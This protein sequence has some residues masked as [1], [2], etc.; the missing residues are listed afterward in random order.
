MDLFVVLPWIVAIAVVVA[1]KTVGPVVAAAAV[2]V[3]VVVVATTRDVVVPVVPSQP[4]C[5]VDRPSTEEAVTVP[6]IA[7]PEDTSWRSVAASCAEPPA[8]RVKYPRIG[9]AWLASIPN[10]A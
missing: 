9:S 1:A 10:R 4:R 5:I 6:R 3:V 2:V 7:G 8:F